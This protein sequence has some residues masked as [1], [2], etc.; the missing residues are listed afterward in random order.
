MTET[1][2]RTRPRFRTSERRV[3]PRDYLSPVPPVIVARLADDEAVAEH[4][5]VVERVAS[6]AERLTLTQLAHRRAKDEAEAASRAAIRAGKAA[7]AKPQN[8]VREL[9]AELLAIA[10]EQQLAEGLLAETAQAV[11][12]ASIAELHAAAEDCQTRERAAL[13]AAEGKLREAI[14]LLAEAGSVAAEGVWVGA[15]IA[16]GEVAPWTRGR[17]VRQ[18]GAVEVGR[19]LEAVVQ[20]RV[21]QAER[22]DELQ[23][24]R[25]AVDSVTV[26]GHTRR[27]PLPPGA[28]V[29]TLPG[30]DEADA[31]TA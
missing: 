16:E 27:L 2:T 14:D 8:R 23:R 29:W 28:T 7:P 31:A 11:L 6:L 18:R 24:E 15:M 4:A 10:D 12:D 30:E 17:T 26:V 13:D 19:A 1:T 3:D 25:V 22:V 21:V 20:G 9:E 5:R